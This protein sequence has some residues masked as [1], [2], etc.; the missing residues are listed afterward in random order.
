MKRS[1]QPL[2]LWFMLW[3]LVLTGTA[4]VLAYVVRFHAGWIPILHEQPD[5]ALCLA[6]LPLVLIL[7]AA[8]YHFT[9]MYTVHRLRRFREELISVLKGTTL[10][11][12][13]IVATVFWRHHP[14]ES[15]IVMALF[16]GLTLGFVLTARRL[17]WTA[18]RF[19][20]QLGYNQTPALIVGTGRV[21]R[22]IA[23]ALGNASWTGVYPLGFVEDQPNRWASDLNIL[24]RTEDLPQLIEK[25][26]V[27]HVFIA[28]PLNRYHE[29]R[30]VFD[31]LSQTLVDVRLVVDAPN[32]A[33]LSLTTTQIDGVTVLGLRES[34]HYG[35]NVVVKRAMDIVLS[36]LALIILS[37]V[38]IVIAI[39]IKLT[40]PGPIFYRQERCS[41]NGKRFQ[42]LKF[43]SMRVDAEAQS[44]PVWCQENDPRRTP[45]GA[46]LRRTSLDELPQLINV[47]K[48]DM[49]LVGP[50]PE[51]PVFIQQF[52][53]TI[54]NYM[55]RHC[56]K[57]GITGWAQ[58]HGWRGNTSLRK[59]IE[60]DLYYITHWNP[61]LD[62]RI[63]FMTAI[64]GWTDKHAY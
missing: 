10:L 33:A 14:Y 64:K 43:R 35:L 31:I 34:P 39:L 5:F 17:S 22:R 21:A 16:Y 1:S 62:L 57:A 41:L 24:G 8:A 28:L 13:L 38:M 9:G 60:Y 23:K 30:R 15:R 25:H 55:I 3:D 50:R 4:W 44:G 19:L 37:P 36:L 49:S 58:I 47:L 63:L 46:F 56:V 40:S 54:P 45:L 12:L 27:G 61:W 42:M 59:R 18:I 29:A 20:R 51:R 7:A 26:R 53:K 2:I 6:D 11:V 48:G 52:K 32:M